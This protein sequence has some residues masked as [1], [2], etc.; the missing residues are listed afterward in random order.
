MAVAE[1]WIGANRETLHRCLSIPRTGREFSEWESW[2][3]NAGWQIV[4]RD[5][6][7][8][9]KA[10]GGDSWSVVAILVLRVASEQLRL[11]LVSIGRE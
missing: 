1:L 4:H 6:Q 7:E 9:Q 11:W 5:A 3:R 8:M 2:L 10:V